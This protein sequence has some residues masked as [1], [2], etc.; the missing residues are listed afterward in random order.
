MSIDDIGAFDLVSRQAMLE[1]LMGAPGARDFLPFVRMFYGEPSE[2]VWYDS[3]G[4]REVITQAEGGE[5]G[6]PLIPALFALGPH[7]QI[8]SA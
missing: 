3:H 6:D 2:Y 5:Q 8:V 7:G 4:N 1:G